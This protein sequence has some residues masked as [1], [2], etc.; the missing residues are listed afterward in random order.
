MKS[1]L[2]LTLILWLVGSTLPAAAQEFRKWD[3]GGSAG[4]LIASNREFGGSIDQHDPIWVWSIDVGR[5]FTAH[6]KAD[7]GLMLTGSHTY[8]ITDL[9]PQGGCCPQRIA[10]PAS[11]SGAATYQFFEN[12]F[13]HPYLSAGVRLTWLAEHRTVF[14]PG[15]QTDPSNLSLVYNPV[16]DEQDT[17]LQLRP[18]VAAG[19]K[20]YFNERTFIRSE[21]LTAVGPHGFSYVLRLGAG[22]DF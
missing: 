22:I 6:L 18:F 21:V 16:T 19:F 8:A 15:Q 9:P 2:S 17:L 4:M 10:R 3:V 12:V 5:Y 20:S 1:A 14:F 7:V 13:A 11:L